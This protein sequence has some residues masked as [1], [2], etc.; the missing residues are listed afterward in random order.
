M[1]SNGHYGGGDFVSSYGAV[2]GEGGQR[3]F[4]VDDVDEVEYFEL[5]FARLAWVQA[6]SCLQ[7]PS[8]REALVWHQACC[9]AALAALKHGK[10]E[11]E[12]ETS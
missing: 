11:E 10:P 1:R 3:D 12:H 4:D 2:T 5:A 7:L 6:T 9:D 8:Q